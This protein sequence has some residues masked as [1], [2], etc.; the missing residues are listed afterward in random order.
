VVDTK[1]PALDLGRV[2]VLQKL[3]LRPDTGIDVISENLPQSLEGIPTVYRSIDLTIDRKGFM[4]NA[5]SCA[6][7]ALHGSFN[8]VAGAMAATSDAPAQA[9]R[10]GRR[11]GRGHP[12]QAPAAAGDDHPSAG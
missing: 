5:T 4:R 1:V 2:A 9:D 8:A 12:R 7:Q 10:E 3:V 11:A 6:P